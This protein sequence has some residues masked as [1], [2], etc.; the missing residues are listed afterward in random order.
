MFASPAGSALVEPA[1]VGKRNVKGCPRPVSV[2]DTG[3]NLAAT[4]MRLQGAQVRRPSTKHQHP[5]RAVTLMVPGHVAM[6]G[7]L[8]ETSPVPTTTRSNH[9]WAKPLRVVSPLAQA[10]FLK[11]IGARAGR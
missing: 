9:D 1:L 8:H 7:A 4:P 11:A 6:I 3:R 10:Y 5:A 2:R